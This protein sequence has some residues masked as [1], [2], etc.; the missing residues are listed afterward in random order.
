MA[1]GTGV[2]VDMKELDRIEVVGDETGLF[3]S[4]A[5]RR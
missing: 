3:E 1:F 2:H 4:L 5:Q